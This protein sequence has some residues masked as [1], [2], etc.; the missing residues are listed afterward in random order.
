MC[1]KELECASAMVTARKNRY[2]QAPFVL[3]QEAI[4]ANTESIITRHR[5]K[6]CDGKRLS[7]EK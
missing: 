2:S 7:Y 3:A 5:I 1:Y 4:M 6:F